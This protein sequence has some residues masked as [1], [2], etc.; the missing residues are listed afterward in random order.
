MIRVPFLFV[1][2]HSVGAE[3]CTTFTVLTPLVDV[4]SAWLFW[5]HG[6]WGV[7]RGWG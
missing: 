2:F 3:A 7:A 5:M 6:S 4:F 1:L